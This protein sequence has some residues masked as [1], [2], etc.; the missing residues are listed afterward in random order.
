MPWN[1]VVAYLRDMN[2]IIV[3]LATPLENGKINE[4]R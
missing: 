4:L 3:Q 1:Q 2:G